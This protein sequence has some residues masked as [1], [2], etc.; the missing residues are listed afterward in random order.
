MS[1]ESRQAKIVE[2]VMERTMEN[3]QAHL[4]QLFP[5][6]K[7]FG[8]ISGTA[9]RLAVYVP[10]GDPMHD[11]IV[12]YCRDMEGQTSYPELNLIVQQVDAA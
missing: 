12:K 11:K 6:V 7:F 8:R 4:L 1:E 2:E 9:L 3:L 5:T 10:S